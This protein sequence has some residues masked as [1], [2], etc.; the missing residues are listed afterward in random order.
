MTRSIPKPTGTAAE[1]MRRLLS[2]WQQSL[3]LH[4]SYLSLD[5][6]HYWHVQPWPE[7]QRPAAWVVRLARQKV[8]ELARTLE[9]QLARKDEHFAEG[10]EQMAFLANLVGLQ[11]AGRHIP[12]ADAHNERPEFLASAKNSATAA[13]RRAALRAQVAEQR[14]GVEKTRE[15]PAPRLKTGLRSGAMRKAPLPRPHELP[16]LPTEAADAP[17]PPDPRVKQ[18]LEDAARLLQWGRKWHE[19]GELISRLAERPALGDVRRIL[20]AHRAQ[21]QPPGTPAATVP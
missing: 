8:A 16:P 11:P 4:T 3:E 15:M 10:L 7:H 1:R 17:A 20:R 19:L 14:S 6:D 9:E 12:L 21:L 5:D 2:R 13:V 18:V